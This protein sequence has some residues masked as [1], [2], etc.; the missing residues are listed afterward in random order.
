MKVS[1]LME[2]LS[3]YHGDSEVVISDDESDEPIRIVVSYEQFNGSTLVRLY[4]GGKE[5]RSDAE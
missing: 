4:R 2:K 3:R 5:G 1:E